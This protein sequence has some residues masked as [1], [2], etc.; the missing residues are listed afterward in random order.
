MTVIIPIKYDVVR[1]GTIIRKTIACNTH[2]TAKRCLAAF[3]VDF[4]HRNYRKCVTSV[5]C[6]T[7]HD[8]T[9]KIST[10]FEVDTSRPTT[11]IRFVVIALLLL[12]HYVT[13]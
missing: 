2:K 11:T 5:T 12:L 3:G 1:C 10:N 13:L 7:P 6:F 9:V 4:I 8:L